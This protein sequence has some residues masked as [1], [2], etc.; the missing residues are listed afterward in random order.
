VLLLSVAVAGCGSGHGSRSPIMISADG[1]IGP[2]RM[3][4]SGGHDVL[5][6]L[7]RPDAD[8]RGRYAEFAPY[9]AL[10]YDCSSTSPD[11]R[12]PLAR[13]TFCRTVFFVNR[14][15]G[16]LGNFFTTSQRYEERHGVRI[17]M[18]TAAAERLLQKRVGSGCS[19]VIFLGRPHASLTIEF[20]GGAVRKV[21]GSTALTIS[22]GHVGAFAMHGPRSDLGVFDCL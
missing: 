14:R 15:T 8:V 4:R 19:D 13:R 12:W 22:G 16:R 6:L 21:R 11:S 5:A 10:G 9:S 7:G 1:R 20:D 3:D 18:A 17:G 2:L